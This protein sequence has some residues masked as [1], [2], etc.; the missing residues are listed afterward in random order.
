[1]GSTFHTSELRCGPCG[2]E[3]LLV[4]REQDRPDFEEHQ[5][6]V[7]CPNG[8]EATLTLTGDT[9]VYY[10]DGRSWAGAV[11]AGAPAVSEWKPRPE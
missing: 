11:H 5:C 2:R 3:Y 1:M 9:S 6:V 7:T 4:T 10:P 8:H